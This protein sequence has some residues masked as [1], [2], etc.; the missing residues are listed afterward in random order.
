MYANKITV[1][2]G[3]KKLRFSFNNIFCFLL[4][5]VGAIIMVL[6]FVW[7]ILSSFKPSVELLKMPPTWLPEKFSLNNFG[8]VLEII[9]FG[10][11]LLNSVFVSVLNASVASFTSALTGYIFAKYK[12]WGK[13]VLF[14]AVLGG[15]MIPFQVIMIPMYSIMIDFNW[16]NTYNVLTIPYFYS[17]F[18]IFLMRQF[19]SKLPNELMESATIDGCSHFGIFFRIIL[20]LVRSA[21]A[22]LVIFLFMGSWNDY[23]WPLIVINSERLRTLPLGLASF[24]TQRSTR[25]DLLMAASLMATIPILIVFFAAQKHFIEG[26]AMT[27][28][29][30]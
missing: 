15:M 18:G 4:L 24:V 14:M 21:M 23:L 16:I 5:L 17:I 2:I 30:S 29:K 26:I 19:I 13:E 1:S 25:Y 12:F 22:A 9:P 8:G 11:F 7:M 27:G 10:R 20:P 3:S 6:P 28:L